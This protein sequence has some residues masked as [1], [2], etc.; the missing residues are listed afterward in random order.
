MESA[1]TSAVRRFVAATD[2]VE[3]TRELLEM[4]AHTPDTFLF[5]TTKLMAG[6][7]ESIQIGA[8]LMA[9]AEKEQMFARVSPDL[10]DRCFSMVFNLMVENSSRERR[11]RSAICAAVASLASV[12]TPKTKLSQL[13]EQLMRFRKCLNGKPQADKEYGQSW[14]FVIKELVKRCYSDI[15]FYD[16]VKLIIEESSLSCI[17]SIVLSGFAE[18]VGAAMKQYIRKWQIKRKDD[19][20]Y[21]MK[22]MEK[23][24][25]KQDNASLEAI[26][27]C[28]RLFFI[29]L[30][31]NLRANHVKQLI[32]ISGSI[33]RT[34]EFIELWCEIFG[35]KFVSYPNIIKTAFRRHCPELVWHLIQNLMRRSGHVE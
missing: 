23:L 27:N 17:D 35:E 8:T 18:L 6:T 24:V 12:N 13:G 32:A 7:L 34:V 16:E 28:F 33:N 1:F 9:L 5:E 3:N 10:V 25:A 30:E 2:K 20:D 29:D 11:T 15:D 22:I 19:L 21:Y 14:Y 4:I 26:R 31:T